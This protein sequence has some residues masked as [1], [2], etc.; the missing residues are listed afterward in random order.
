[1]TAHLAVL[2]CMSGARASHPVAVAAAGALLQ[3]APL[4]CPGSSPDPVLLCL[5][6]RLLV[7]LHPWCGAACEACRYRSAATR[8]AEAGKVVGVLVTRMCAARCAAVA[9]PNMRSDLLML[10]VL[11]A[12]GLAGWR[13]CWL[14]P[15]VRR[16]ADRHSP[17]QLLCHGVDWVF[18]QDV[19]SLLQ[20]PG[21]TPCITHGK[22]DQAC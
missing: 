2:R 15:L 6:S 8:T 18:L 3:L 12:P 11:H 22:S 17:L 10:L 4:L 20:R 1:M 16:P 14:F 5:L 13:L 7:L 21:R 19:C 9:V